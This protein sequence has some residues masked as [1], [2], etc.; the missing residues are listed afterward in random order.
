[1]SA[2]QTLLL[3]G[4][5]ETQLWR[6]SEIIAQSQDVRSDVL[7]VRLDLLHIL[8]LLHRWDASMANTLDHGEGME[9]ESISYVAMAE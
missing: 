5:G 6:L 9:E 8:F 1:M 2:C 4:L 3:R 7:L